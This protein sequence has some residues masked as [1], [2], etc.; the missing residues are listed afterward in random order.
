MWIKTCVTIVFN[1]CAA[2]MKIE[3]VPNQ[4][5]SLENG[6]SICTQWIQNNSS[7][8]NVF[9]DNCVTINSTT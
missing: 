6:A 7:F 2:F 1:E 8:S 3:Y 5:I 4:Q 9:G